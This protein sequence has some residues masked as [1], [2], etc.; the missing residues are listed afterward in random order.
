M[1]SIC[2]TGTVYLV[3]LGGGKLHQL[4]LDAA[5]TQLAS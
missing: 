3:V 1:K 4:G 2:T 5:A